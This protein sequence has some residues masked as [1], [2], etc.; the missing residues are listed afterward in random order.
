[1]ISKSELLGSKHNEKLKR[2]KDYVKMVSKVIKENYPNGL[3]FN[4]LPHVERFL[5]HQDIEIEYY[6]GLEKELVKA[7][8][9]SNVFRKMANEL[10]DNGYEYALEAH[11]NYSSSRD[12][13]NINLIIE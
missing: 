7:I 1:M 8:E 4:E 10:I 3:E 6:T 2:F 12:E 9:R 11:V 5:Y 13:W